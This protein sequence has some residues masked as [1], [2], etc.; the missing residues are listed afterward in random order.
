MKTKEFAEPGERHWQ[1]AAKILVCILEQHYSLMLKGKFAGSN[2]CNENINY[3]KELEETC[4]PTY[5]I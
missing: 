5:K 3:K 1:S 4:F 2:S